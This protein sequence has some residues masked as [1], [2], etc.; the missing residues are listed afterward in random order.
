MKENDR[1]RNI[2]R[3]YPVTAGESDEEVQN[4]G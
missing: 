2:L 4:T 1:S 3:Q